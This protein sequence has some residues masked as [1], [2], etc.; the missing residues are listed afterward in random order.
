MSSAARVCAGRPGRPG[1]VDRRAMRVAEGGALDAV[2]LSC[3]GQRG[4][5]G[6]DAADGRAPSGLS[7]LRITPP[8]GDVTAGR[9]VGEPQA[10]Q[11]ADAS[12]GNGDDLPEAEHQSAASR[13]QGVSLPAARTCDRA[14]EPGLVCGHH[15]YSDGQGV[16]VSGGGDGLVQPPGPGVAGVDQPGDDFCVEALQEAMERHGQP[17]IFNTDQGVQFTSAD[18]LAELERAGFGSAW[19]ARG[20]IWTTSSSSGCGEA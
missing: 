10:G 12:D 9:L 19:M 20:G 11:A 1:P 4:G 6:A 14:G 15:L 7:V 17:D 2:L 8:G 18:F 16:R 5:S 13:S 3:A